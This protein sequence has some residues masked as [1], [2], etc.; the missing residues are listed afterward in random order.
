MSCDPFAASCPSPTQA[1][2]TP[3]DIEHF[4]RCGFLF[5]TDVL[6]VHA[7]DLV[8]SRFEGMFK[9]DFETG[10]YPDEW[11]WREGISKENVTREICN[12]WKS[13]RT[14]ISPIVLSSTLGKIVAEVKGWKGVRLGQDDIFWKPPGG[15]KELCFHQDTPYFPITPADVLTVW[16]ALDDTSREV[17]TLE[18]VAGSHLWSCASEDDAGPSAGAAVSTADTST[19]PDSFFTQIGRA[20]CRERV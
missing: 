17:G 4:R 7:C 14:A 5:L 11:H 8:V 12:A 9:G 19:P 18:Y 20:S 15:T 10:V 3:A 6:P 2:T 13:D 1:Y 16:I